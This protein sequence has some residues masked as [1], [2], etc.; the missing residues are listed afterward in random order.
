MTEKRFQWNERIDGRIV[1]EFVVDNLIKKELDE[2]DMCD[3]L[4]KLNDEIKEL[5]FQL[6]ECGEHRLYSRRKLEEENKE[7]KDKYERKDRQ[8]K[9]TKKDIEKYTDYFMNELN[10]DCDRIIKEVFR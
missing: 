9:R 10:W 4:N 5:K 8:L 6:K 2:E 3:L 1:E 7:L